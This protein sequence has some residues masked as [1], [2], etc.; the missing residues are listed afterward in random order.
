MKISNEKIVNS[1]GV[2]S[3]VTGMDLNIKVSYAIAKNISKIEKELEIYNKEKGK[4]LDKYAFKDEEGKIKS[5][6]DG[7]VDID[8]IENWNKDIKELL[9]IENDI[10]IHLIEIED[11][12]KCS[13]NITPGE[14]MLISYMFK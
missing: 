5:N 9:E 10:D 7:A 1:I 8:D 6:K 3:K 11:L 12:S 13:C 14:L 4:L 2:L